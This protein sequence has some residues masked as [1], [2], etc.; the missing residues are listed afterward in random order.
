MGMSAEMG[1][2]HRNNCGDRI[3]VGM[4]VGMETV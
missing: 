1:A 4:N 2:I 3:R